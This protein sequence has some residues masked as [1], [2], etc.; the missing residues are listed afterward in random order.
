MSPVYN[1]AAGQ[2]RKVEAI[3]AMAESMLKAEPAITVPPAAAIPDV[4]PKR[5]LPLSQSSVHDNTSRCSVGSEQGAKV[6]GG[7]GG[8]KKL[9]GPEQDAVVA[10]IRSAAKRSA[11]P[12]KQ[13]P[14]QDDDTPTTKSLRHKK[15]MEVIVFLCVEC[16]EIVYKRCTGCLSPPA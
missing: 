15:E 13:L 14:F 2:R 6:G 1:A 3:L 7:G 11:S 9:S 4:T 12:E 16:P 5:V 8:S 10:K